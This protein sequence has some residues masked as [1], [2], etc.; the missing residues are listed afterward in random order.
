MNQM[1]NCWH[2][3]IIPIHPSTPLFFLMLQG[4]HYNKCSHRVV[5]GHDLF[6]HSI[7]H[8]LIASDLAVIPSHELLMQS[9]G[10]AFRLDLGL[11]NVVFRTSNPNISDLMSIVLVIYT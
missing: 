3:P 1:T 8:D 9:T 6:M 4:M 10:L 5:S 7:C 2:P 11:A